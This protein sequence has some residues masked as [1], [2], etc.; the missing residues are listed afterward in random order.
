MEGYRVDV[1]L[2]QDLGAHAR[3]HDAL[4]QEDAVVHFYGL[5]FHLIFFNGNDF[6]F[7]LDR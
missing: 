7:Y 2:V 5:L 3:G 1:G 6:Y 4:V